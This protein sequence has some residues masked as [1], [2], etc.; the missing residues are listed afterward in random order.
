MVVQPAGLLAHHLPPDTSAKIADSEPNQKYNQQEE[1]FVR[2]PPG[3][4]NAGER[5][6]ASADNAAKLQV[7]IIDAETG[8]PTACRVNVVGPNGNYYEPDDS[9]LEPFNAHNAG[10]HRNGETHPPSRY[11]GWYF[12]TLG[13]FAVNV[14]KGDVRIEVWKGYEYLPVSKHV[15]SRTASDAP[16]EIKITRTAAM[17]KQGYWSG[18]TH[19]HMDRRNDED[20]RQALHLMAAEDIRYG[21][22]LCMNDP[23]DYSGQMQRQEWPQQQ[24]FGA[25]SVQ[26][27]GKYGIVSAQEYRTKTY[28]HICLLM[29]DRL[30]FEGAAYNPNN[31]PVFGMVGKMTSQHG[32]YAFHAHGGYSKEIYADYV[33]Q[34]TH[35]VELLQMA[36]YRGIGLAG[37]YRILNIG[38]R[39][40]AL[41]GSDFPYVRALGDCRTFVHSDKQPTFAEWTRQAAEGRSFFT[42]GPLLLL[43]VEGKRP[44]DILDLDGD[45]PQQLIVKLRVRCEVT[46]VQHIALLVNG[47]PVKQW[48]LSPDEN[49]TGVW[50]EYEFKIEVDKPC[51][52]AAR[53]HGLSTTGRSDAEAHTNPIYVYRNG[54]KPFH[55]ADRDWL[56]KQLDGQIEELEERSFPE[57]EQALDFFLESRRQ[58]LEK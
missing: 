50:H 22:I 11:Y 26:S 39:F 41:G 34:A 8:K 3:F 20:T 21:F 54:D 45:Q 19:I 57:K 4:N 47:N 52:I 17:H 23:R 58:L 35:G 49:N 30:V 9:P 48:T 7:K 6:V 2:T 24:G 12:Y 36:H 1:D 32:G 29:H 28:G 46:P 13:E 31:W 44:G 40:P 10:C 43:E 56:V 38:Y 37:W 27:Q 5:K 42:T 53:A 18:D 55:A 33:Q 14:P 25:S 15:S 51:W 16:V